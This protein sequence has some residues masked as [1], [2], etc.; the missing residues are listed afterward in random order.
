MA[1]RFDPYDPAAVALW[2]GGG[3]DDNGRAPER[4][5]ARGEGNPCRSCLRDIGEGAP[6]LIL[7]A[8]PFVG[9]HA[10]AETGP[11]FL[12]AEP[13]EP[14]AG[15]GVPPILATSPDYLVKGYGPDERIVY[16]TGR[17][18]PCAAVGA[19]CADLLGGAA[20]AFVD[21]RSARN[22]CFQARARRAA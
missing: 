11:I 7:G 1:I 4:A 20:V 22:N 14:W 12:H 18:V 16:G 2:R 5:L 21:I 13:C 3:A 17:I 6:M 15:A 19:Y 10:Y 9:R 8:R